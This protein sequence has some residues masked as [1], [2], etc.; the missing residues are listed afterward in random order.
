M[1][2]VSEEIWKSTL[3]SGT[4]VL[5]QVNCPGRLARDSFALVTD[6][7]I[8]LKEDGKYYKHVLEGEDVGIIMWSYLE[9]K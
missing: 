4:F 1:I 5:L 9:T 7:P 8:C 3:A 2:K 6:H